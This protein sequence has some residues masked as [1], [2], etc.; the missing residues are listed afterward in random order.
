MESLVSGRV[1][2][3]PSLGVGAALPD[4]RSEYSPCSRNFWTLA[5]VNKLVAVH[6][7]IM[8]G[9]PVDLER[10]GVEEVAGAEDDNDGLVEAALEIPEADFSAMGVRLMTSMV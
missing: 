2:M 7:T 3:V 4:G 5:R 1:M 6:G 8:I 10:P 9:N